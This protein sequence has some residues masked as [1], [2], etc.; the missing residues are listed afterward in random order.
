MLSIIIPVLNESYNLPQ[1]LNHLVLKATA[2]EQLE[3]VIVDGGSE[4]DTLELAHKFKRDNLVSV[5]IVNSSR[6]RAKQMNTGAGVATGDIL[7]FLHADSFPPANYDMLI[8]DEVLKGNLAG[9]F[10]MK[11]DN[12]H[13]WLRLASYLTKFSWRA[14]RGGDQSQFITRTLFDEIGGYDEN[15]I[16]YEDN[17]LIN[18]LYA[19]NEY[20]VIQHPLISSARLYEKYGVWFVQYH[21]W[22]IYVKKWMGAS[23]EE[24]H[25]YYKKNLK[26]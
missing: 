19:R 5:H 4:D 17:I 24:L 6:G 22:T 13:W 1:L 2:K 12:E 14:C 8:Q 3:L 11:F 15:Y 7:Y 26:K 18:E 10:R 23:A 9:C 21:F 25:A 20:V 16:I